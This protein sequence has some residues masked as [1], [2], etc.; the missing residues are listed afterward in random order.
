MKTTKSDRTPPTLNKMS[1]LSFHIIIILIY[2]SRLVQAVCPSLCECKWKSGKESVVCLNASLTI[3][4]LLLDPGTQVLDLTGNNIASIRHEEFSKAGLVN[5]QKVYI[6]KC[7]LKTLERYSFKYLINLVDLDLSYNAL[8]NIPSHT[9]D[10]V[11]ELRELKLNGNPIQKIFNDAFM[12]IPQLIRLEISDCKIAL[13]EPRAFSGSEKSLE[14]LKLDNN[15]LSEVIARS[16]TG[17]QNLHGLELAGN[18]WNC[19]CSLRP[20]REWM[21]RQNVPFGIPPVCYSPKRLYS[22]S[23]DKLDLDEYACVPEI[24]AYDSKAHG[25]EGKNVTMTCKISGIPEPNVRWMLKN[26]VIANLSGSPIGGAKKLY[27]VHMTNSSSDLTIFSADLQDAGTYV[28]AAENKAG[29]AE[30]SVNLAVSRKPPE[31]GFSNKALIASVVTGI[32]FVLISCLISL[33]I[34][35]LRKKQVLKWRSRE[36]GRDD[37]YEKIEMN[38]KVVKVNGG[39]SVNQD[40]PVVVERRNGEYRVVPGGETDQEV[41]EEEESN[42]DASSSNKKWNGDDRSGEKGWNSP[43]H[44]LDPEDL[45]IPRRTIQENRDNIKRACSSTCGTYKQH[46]PSSSSPAPMAPS[47]PLHTASI[48]RHVPVNN[49]HFANKELS[50]VAEDAEKQFPDLLESSPKNKFFEN[51]FYCGGSRTASEGG[52]VSDINEI[53]CTLPRRKDL[54]HCSRYRSCDSQSPLLSDSRYGSSGGESYL[55]SQ[56]YGHRRMSDFQ[57]N[58]FPMSLNKNRMNKISNSYLNLSR[59]DNI[60]SPREVPVEMNATP[61]LDVSS[62]ESRVLFNKREIA[63][64]PATS[65]APSAAAYD[66][67]AAQLERFLEEYRTLQKQLTKMKETCD[68]LCLEKGKD[69]KPAPSPTNPSSSSSS[70]PANSAISPNSLEDSVDF[71]NFETELTNYLIS[72]K[73]SP[74]SFNPLS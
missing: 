42:V 58:T 37:N 56:D 17:L 53:F 1:T 61:L 36:C 66:Y 23:W 12:H 9:F 30:A 48:R 74:N 55:G 71:K 43:E 35:S 24:F 28:C 51:K 34:C 8:A 44:L 22:K 39:V 16:F 33:C 41:E 54:A 73:L 6:T 19:S 64:S 26:K 31:G 47:T 49:P 52:S 40:L 65:T 29:K 45:H 7:R 62:L 13:I 70:N 20:L 63:S 68:N 3:I 15:K 50:R 11:T 59:E 10:S 2:Y 25:I 60:S 57:K 21:L 46:S 69:Q 14:W 4:P 18:P 32:A 67:H 27:V 38:H 5:L 72:K